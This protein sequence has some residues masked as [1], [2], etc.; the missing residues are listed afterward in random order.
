MNDPRDYLAHHEYFS[1][2]QI[3]IVNWKIEGK[4]YREIANAWEIRYDSKI[5]LEAIGVCLARTGRGLI[6]NQ[7]N[8]LG[9]DPYL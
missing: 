3:S 9:T 2:E 1:E 5:S 6:W 8:E 7:S 4:T